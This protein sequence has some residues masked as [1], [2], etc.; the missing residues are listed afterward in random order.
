MYVRMC[1]HAGVCVR[2]C[3]CAHVCVHAV[4]LCTFTQQHVFVCI[5]V[6]AC[7]RVYMWLMAASLI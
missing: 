1:V 4:S 3:M 5:Y 6:H 7:T 2:V